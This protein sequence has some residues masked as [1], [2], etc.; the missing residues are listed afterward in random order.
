MEQTHS[1]AID[2]Q[3]D[4]RKHVLGDEVRYSPL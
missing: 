4:V 1:G 3:H 2:S